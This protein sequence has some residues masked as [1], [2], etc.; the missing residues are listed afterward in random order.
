MKNDLE[1][2]LIYSF[3]KPLCESFNEVLKLFSFVVR[4]LYS[5][6]LLHPKFPT[7]FYHD[8]SITGSGL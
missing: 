2:Y 5:L 4:L 1:L 3:W 7:K 8:E 6:S